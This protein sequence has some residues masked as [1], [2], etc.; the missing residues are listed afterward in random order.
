MFHARSFKKPYIEFLDMFRGKSMI[1][2]YKQM[3][4]LLFCLAVTG[5]MQ[6]FELAKVFKK[7][8]RRYQGSSSKNFLGHIKG[9][10][11]IG[12]F[13]KMF[14]LVSRVKGKYLG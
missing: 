8:T 1:T 3:R 11:K 14:A 2:D 4:Q 12:N 10:T 7:S 9:L 13:E 6:L 5:N